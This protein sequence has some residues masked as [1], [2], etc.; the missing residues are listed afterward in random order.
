MNQISNRAFSFG[1]TSLR[2]NPHR[3][4]VQASPILNVFP[5]P[6]F[7]TD[8]YTHSS[9]SNS[10][11]RKQRGVLGMHFFRSEPMKNESATTT[12]S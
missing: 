4:D 9:R 8:T 3:H 7:F 6:R 12:G 11:H 2:M 10:T 1:S 5:A